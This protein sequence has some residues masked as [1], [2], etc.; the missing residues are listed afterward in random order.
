ML[1]DDFVARVRAWIK[2]TAFIEIRRFVL[3][4]AVPLLRIVR[5]RHGKLASV[6]HHYVTAMAPTLALARSTS[7]G[8]RPVLRSIVTFAWL[9]QAFTATSRTWLALYS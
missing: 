7:S 9:P 8:A 5:K 6:L 4:P 2:T 3:A 1:L